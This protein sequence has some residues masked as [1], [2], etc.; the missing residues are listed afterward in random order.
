MLCSRRLEDLWQH[1]DTPHIKLLTILKVL[2]SSG[3]MSPK[4]LP[5]KK[6]VG[7]AGI[8]RLG[9]QASQKAPNPKNKLRLYAK[10]P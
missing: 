1:L 5:P 9:M 10:Q 2:R 3:A 6:S 7:V 8:G 4:P